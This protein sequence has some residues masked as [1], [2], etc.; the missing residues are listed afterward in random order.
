MWVWTD[1]MGEPKM[2]FTLNIS[3]GSPNR[4]VIFFLFLKSYLLRKNAS[5]SWYCFLLMLSPRNQLNCD[6]KL[7]SICLKF[8]LNI[9]PSTLSKFLLEMPY[10]LHQKPHHRMGMKNIDITIINFYECFVSMHLHGLREQWCCQL[11]PPFP[12]SG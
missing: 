1:G 7:D 8:I 5:N 4:F 3:S 6:M 9:G 2:S 10:F 12:E 11:L